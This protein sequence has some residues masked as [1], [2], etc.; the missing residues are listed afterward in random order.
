M[1]ARDV[2][3][4]GLDGVPPDLL[5]TG[6]A[7]GRLP[8]LERLQ[9]EGA[10][11][12]TRSTI[13]PISMMAWSTFA[14]GRHPSGHGVFNFMRK[15][16]GG[17]DTEFVNAEHLRATA[18]PFWEYLDARG[19]STGVMNV[20]PGYPASRT[21]GF[22]IVDHITTPRN[23]TVAYPPATEDEF[24]ES[25]ERF[26]IGPPTGAGADMD[27][28]DLDAYL[29]RFF[30]VERDR[31]EATKRTIEQRDYRASVLVF[32]GPDVLLHEIGY[33]RDPSH[34]AYD[35]ALADRYADVP[36]DLLEA[37]DDFLGW[38]LDRT[39]EDDAIVVLSD[40]G[41]GPLYRAVNLNAWLYQEGFLSLRSS[42]TTLLKQF[43][44]N[45]LF[46]A[47]ESLTKRLDVYHTI[48][49]AVARSS[50]SGG[51]GDGVDWSSLLTISQGDV[52][53]S[54]TEVFTVAG[55]GQLWVNTTDHEAGI[56]EEAAY[57]RVRERLRTQLLDLTD[58]ETGRQVV[59]AVEDG[60]D[61]YGDGPAR[62]PDL[63]CVPEPGYR[64]MFPQTMQTNRVF[65]TPQKP[66]SHTSAAEREGI[67]LA[68]GKDVRT[69]DDVTVGLEEYAPSLLGLLGLPV[70]DVMDGTPRTDIFEI[71]ADGREPYANRVAVSRA[72]HDA[73]RTITEK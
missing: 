17:Y 36:L 32:S 73:A 59:A 9:Q 33:L 25:F 4:V 57:E 40:H 66:A 30:D 58:P 39:T 70:A 49:R 19:I 56:V 35:P 11:G 16:E 63:V 15:A 34:P 71:E 43:G 51:D 61:V 10:S 55:D 5:A 72:A 2:Y 67:F 50:G 12:T 53:W 47:F 42:P 6:I 60:E 24:R 54:E 20:M 8:N 31:I 13:P 22:H 37:Y 46:G 48:K 3:V 65:D 38:L 18:T 14:T 44:Y 62:C 52:D 64:F 7:D 28:D 1:T 68:W 45:H 29:D 69:A 21:R 23:G 41:H 26:S 27:A